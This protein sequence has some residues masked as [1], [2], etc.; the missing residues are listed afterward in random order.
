MSTRLDDDAIA[1]ALR[2]LP[3]WERNGEAIVKTFTF[4][5]FL[6]G[7]AFV[8][9]VAQVAEDAN[10]HPDVDIRYTRVACALST[11]DAGGITASD[12]ELAREIERTAT[13]HP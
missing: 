13:E 1:S 4:P 5:T 8:A 2:T 12:V 9:R 11:H 7:I 6:Q 3:G 10:H